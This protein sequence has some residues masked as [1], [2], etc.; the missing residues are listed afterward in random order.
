M[1]DLPEIVADL[2]ERARYYAS[3]TELGLPRPLPLARGFDH[4]RK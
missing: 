1:S 4:L 2:R 3:L